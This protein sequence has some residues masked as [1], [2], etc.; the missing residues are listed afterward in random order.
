[1]PQ[2]PVL[3]DVLQI[4]PGSGD[5]LTVSRDATSGGLKFTDP[6]I[7]AGVLLSALV[8]VRGITGVYI[9]GRA[10]DGAPYTSV[11]D[12]LDAV[13][14]SASAASPA[15]I[16]VMPG[17]YVGNVVV[18]RDGVYITSLGG[19]TL[20]NDGDSDTVQIRASLE[21]TPQDFLM[22]GITVVNDRAGRACVRF[23]GA[24]SFASGTVT[25]DA[26]PLAVGDMITI[27]GTSLTGV[28]GSRTPGSNDFSVASMDPT[29]VAAEIA[30][31]INDPANSFSTLVS[32]SSAGPV[33]TIEAVTAGAGGNAIT[34][35]A[36]VTLPGAV[37]LSGATLAGGGA[38]G[39]LVASGEAVL[40]NCWLQATD[41]A[42]FV[43]HAD[44]V[45]NVRVQ[46]GTFKGSHPFS[47]V[48]AINVASLRIYGVERATAFAL[49]YE[50]SAGQPATVSSI[51]SIANCGPIGTIAANL[52]DVSDL[53]LFNNYLVGDITFGGG[54][55]VL[56]AWD[57]RVG[58]LTLSDSSVVALNRCERGS[59]T[60]AG[61]APT[62]EESHLIDTL[63][64]VASVSET[65]T[66]D[67]AQPDTGYTVLLESPDPGVVLA[68]TNKTVSGFDVESNVA[69]TGTVGLSIVRKV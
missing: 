26:V 29:V 6:A 67:I 44:T 1:M 3:T 37:T 47:S 35:A 23:I 42:G 15:L 39:S 36:S 48:V 13:P 46:G 20:V 21:A 45:N 63:E 27:G 60:L 61:G 5:T 52:V 11:Q 14:A 41:A 30:D 4:E 12:A 9:V 56:S 55:Q 17:R 8:G 25:I 62:L 28:I 40:D 32:A 2:P 50:S 54:S 18:E 19:A 68:V 66:F 24:D 16:L 31:A 58:D 33:A 38:A 34:L 10:G 51:Y 69:L 22:R 65:Y 59:L 49:S 57:S 53:Y 7:P 43:L 64:F